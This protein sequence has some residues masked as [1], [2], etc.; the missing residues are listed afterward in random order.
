MDRDALIEIAAEAAAE[1]LYSDP[2]GDYWMQDPPWSLSEVGIDGAGVNLRGMAKCI[3]DAV[4]STIRAAALE[5]AAVLNDCECP[6]RDKVLALPPNSA[7][8]WRTCGQ[9]DC[10]AI[11]AAAIRALINDPPPTL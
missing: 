9:E 8:R 7:E 3:L 2:R 5:E 10:G 1:Y 11:C 6:H 4:A